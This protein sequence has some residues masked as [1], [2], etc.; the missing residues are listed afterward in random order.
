[1]AHLDFKVT[2]WK[3]LYI[4]DNKVDEV[5]KRLKESDCHEVYDLQE[6]EGV[7]FVN[8]HLDQ[9]CEEPM[10]LSENEGAATQ[11]IFNYEGNVIYHNSDHS[12][13]Y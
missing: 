9:E 1:M 5:I 3:R 2:T 4:P 8:S 7:Y 10:S 11:E 6:I 13:E 12:Y